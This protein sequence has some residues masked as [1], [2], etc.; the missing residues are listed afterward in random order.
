[1]C[2]LFFTV[3]VIVFYVN[4]NRD[5]NNKIL[6]VLFRKKADVWQQNKK[7]IDMFGFFLHLCWNCE[8]KSLTKS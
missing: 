2:C 8:K 3:I 1:M 5:L 7:K 6:H 4:I